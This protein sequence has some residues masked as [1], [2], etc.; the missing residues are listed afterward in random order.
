MNQNE[1]LFFQKVN[2][3]YAYTSILLYLN[4]Q[5]R[6]V[7]NN[8]LRNLTSKISILY[9]FQSCPRGNPIKQVLLYFLDF[10]KV[11]F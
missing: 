1:T 3:K 5:M 11:N 10:I 6:Q 7:F 4:I 2:Q 9:I 8:N